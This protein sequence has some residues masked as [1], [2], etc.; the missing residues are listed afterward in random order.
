MKMNT[1]ATTNPTSRWRLR[2]IATAGVVTLAALV[3]PAGVSANSN[4]K[5]E[6]VRA[7]IE[8]GT[9]EV[10]GTSR[11]DALAIRLKPGDPNRVEVDVGDDG[12][13]EFSFARKNLSAINVRIARGDDSVRIDDANGPFTDA[14]PTTIAGGAGD[15]SLEGG[16]GAETFRGGDGKDRIGGGRGND[17][18]FLG[19]GRDAFRWDPG[20]GSDAIEGEDGPDAMLF[21]G[22][23][24]AENITMSAVGGRLVFLRDV[25]LVAMVTDGVETV[26]FNALDGADT[27]AVNDLTGT[28]VT[29][30]NLDLAENLGGDTGDGAVDSVVVNATAR[31]DTINID[32]NGSG[33]DVTGLATAVSLTHAEPTDRLSVNTL[34]GT[35]NV[36]ANGVA[37]VLQVLIDGS[38]V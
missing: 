15:D 30:T 17:N 4:A 11:A 35:D 16:L 23:G 26:D 20:D 33:A 3:A 5:P 9:L 12:S 31:D 27:I 21:N 29:N 25:G 37:G 18:A 1:H 32:G 24:V 38:P 10:K 2:L 19:R 28:D 34:A 8:R 6:R 22:A 14:I 13:G 7:Q 36:L